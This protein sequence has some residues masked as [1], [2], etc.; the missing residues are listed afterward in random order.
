MKENNAKYKI[1]A[2]LSLLICLDF[3]YTIYSLSIYGYKSLD[4]TGNARNN[5][6]LLTIILF[7]MIIVMGIYSCKVKEAGVNRYVNKIISIVCLIFAILSLESFIYIRSSE[8]KVALKLESDT[9]FSFGNTKGND[10][11]ALE[12]LI[13]QK[14]ND[15]SYERKEDILYQVK[16]SSTVER[17]I[18]MLIYNPSYKYY[19]TEATVRTQIEYY[20]IYLYMVAVG[21]V[22]SIFYYINSIERTNK[23]ETFYNKN[24]KENVI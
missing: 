19:G 20:S 11:K 24:N 10:F 18:S 22:N 4:I 16:K 6:I 14:I 7:I 12:N 1:L 23:D 21:V 9:G 8:E 2:T 13:E 17:Y 3:I 15:E 5:Q